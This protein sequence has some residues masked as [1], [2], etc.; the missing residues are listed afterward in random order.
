MA[1]SSGDQKV[2]RRRFM[3]YC[4]NECLTAV[5]LP[6]TSV[7]Q[8]TCAC[9]FSDHY[10]RVCYPCEAPSCLCMLWSMHMQSLRGFKSTKSDCTCTD[11]LQ[12]V[13]Y[14]L[15]ASALPHASR[16]KFRYLWHLGSCW[17]AEICISVLE[18][19]TYCT[20]L[21]QAPICFLRSLP[22]CLTV[23]HFFILSKAEKR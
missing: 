11:C 6:I 14:F 7:G 12:K 16:S 8:A 2:V 9:L 17:R 23:P 13:C 20:V 22:E 3:T 15:E 10:I 5:T 4:M 21:F 18:W 19:N 1:Y